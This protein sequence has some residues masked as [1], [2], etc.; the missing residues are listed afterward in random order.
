MEEMN[1]KNLFSLSPEKALFCI[2]T[3]LILFAMPIIPVSHTIMCFTTPCN[4]I[5]EFTSTYNIMFGDTT[6]IN[7]SLTTYLAIFLEII[8]SY[9]IACAVIY[10]SKTKE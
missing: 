3:L 2:I 10:G 1:L 4:P 9:I 8:V 6:Y 7:Y 5:A